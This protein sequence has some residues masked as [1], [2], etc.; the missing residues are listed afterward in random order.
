MEKKKQF[1][2]QIIYNCL[3]T[4]QKT[5]QKQSWILKSK[6]SKISYAK[7]NCF[8]NT[9]YEQLEFEIKEIIPFMIAPKN[10]KLRYKYN[11]MCTRCIYRKLQNT[12]ERNQRRSKNIVRMSII[13]SWIY[14]SNTIPINTPEKYFIYRKRNRLQNVY[15]KA[16]DLL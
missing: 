9:S 6:Y 4:K 13:P 5:L 10:E 8:P 2:S 3:W 12:D 7:E 15:G 14:K 1:Y 16:S 11:K